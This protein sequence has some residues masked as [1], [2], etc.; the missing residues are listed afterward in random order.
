MFFIALATAAFTGF[1]ALSYEIIWY[2][3]VSLLTWGSPA[4]FGVLL[5]A[6]LFG[7]ALGSI[8][9]RRFCKD[10]TKKGDPGPLRALAVFVFFANAASFLV[11]PAIA[12][13]ATKGSPVAPLVPIAIAAALMGAVLPLL[14]HF[15]IAP[16][17]RA[18]VRLSYLYLANIIGSALGSLVTGFVFMDT[19]TM[20]QIGT[21]LAALGFAISGALWLVSR[22]TSAR[23]TAGIAAVAGAVIAVRLSAPS[24]FDRL[25]EKLN[26]KTTFEDQR[27]EQVLENKHGVIAVGEDGT[28]YG[29]GAYDGRLNTSIVHDKN[30]IVRAYAVGAMHPAPKQ[31][32]M[33]GLSS[34]SWAQVISHLPGVEHLT[35]IEINPGYL[36]VIR[37]HPDVASVLTNPKI[38]IQIDDGRRYLLRHPADTYDFIVM[39]MTYHWRAHA[40]NLLSA[41][42]MQLAR[43]HMK[44]GGVFFF[45]TTSSDDVQKTAVTTFPYGLRL[46]NFFAVSDSPFELDRERF[47]SILSTMQIDGKPVI[48]LTTQDG[49]E[50][51]ENLLTLPDTMALGPV[52]GWGMESHAS[53]LSR[54]KDATI[55]TDDN[56]VAEFRKPLRFPDP[57]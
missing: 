12:Y 3:V 4:S 55:V 8:G 36:E 46:I 35:V 16:D 34:G 27:F 1:V 56:M 7:I 10:G 39:N 33:I 48:D 13:A 30:A 6:Y 9:S 32:L 57:E 47:R 18:G 20:Q 43:A 49:R 24:L 54:T 26:F 50:L 5:G 23:A 51:L 2:R 44:P 21:L 28:V 38:D 45:N 52:P 53:M 42:F 19:M 37:T 31:M 40:T 29:G 14:A 25:Y 22:P 11:V 15:A 41:E 17:D